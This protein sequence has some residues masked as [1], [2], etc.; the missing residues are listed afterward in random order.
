[1]AI[2]MSFA[3]QTIHKPGIYGPTAKIVLGPWLQYISSLQGDAD[4]TNEQRLHRMGKLSALMGIVSV[5][6]KLK[7]KVHKYGDKYVIENDLLA[8]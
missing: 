8:K 6:E 4:L 7:V 2:K 1:M 3:G 5:L